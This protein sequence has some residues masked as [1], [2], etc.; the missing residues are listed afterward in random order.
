MKKI[1]AILLVAVFLFGA[2][3]CGAKPEE[4]TQVELSVPE[5]TTPVEEPVSI[6]MPDGSPMVAV[7]QWHVVGLCG[8]GNVLATGNDANG[9]CATEEWTDVVYVAAD[10]NDT[11][12]LKADGT[13]VFTG[14]HQQDWADAAA[15][16]GAARILIDN[17]VLAA[18][19]TDGSVKATSAQ[20]AYVQT[21]FE[22]ETPAPEMTDGDWSD[23]QQSAVG[24]YVSAGLKAD[25]SVVTAGRYVD[26]QYLVANWNLTAGVPAGSERPAAVDPNAEKLAAAKEQNGDVIGYLHINHTELDFPVL[27]DDWSDGDWYYNNHDIN[28]KKT[29]S[30]GAGSVYALTSNKP[31]KI[32][33]ITGH[34]MRVS[35]TMMHELHHVQEFNG[36]QSQCQGKDCGVALSDSLPNL[37]LYGDRVWNITAYDHTRWEVFA[38]YEVKADE[39]DTTI[40]YNTNLT[41]STTDENLD[42]WIE[43][44]LSRSEVN[45]GVTP[46]VDDTFLCLYTCGTEYDY[47][48]AQSRLYYF[49]RAVD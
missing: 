37:T 28:K 3:A 38:M 36:G 21:D 47:S 20:A 23:V 24:E 25:G 41:K 1:L 43:Y 29:G 34:N 35:A 12:G 14:E 16:T 40:F 2:A 44:Q 49:L 4:T 15:W 18:L 11:A 10:G 27:W 39:P 22:K 42:K 33:T 13:V 8:D 6:A 31:L 46:T 48:T 17:G 19:L 7:G 32:N 30:P 5:E 9:Q 26:A 45:L